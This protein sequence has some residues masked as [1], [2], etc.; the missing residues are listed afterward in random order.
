MCGQ[1]TGKE[2]YK[3]LYITDF[4]VSKITDI[5]QSGVCVKECPQETTDALEWAPTASVKSG[6]TLHVYQSHPVL[7]YCIPKVS[8]L[9]ET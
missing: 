5:F 1:E 8:T 7:T 2:A 4:S 6:A 9:S 3:Y